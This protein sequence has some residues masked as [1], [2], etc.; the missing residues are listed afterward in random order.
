[1]IKLHPRKDLFLAEM[2]AVLLGLRLARKLWVPPIIIKTDSS[3]VVQVFHG[4]IQECQL[5]ARA[6]FVECCDML[7]VIPKAMVAYVKRD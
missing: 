2:E 5:V 4:H 6:C 7:N 1:M 3:Q